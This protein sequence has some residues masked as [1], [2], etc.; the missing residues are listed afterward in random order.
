LAAAALRQSRDEPI[1]TS[2]LERWEKLRTIRLPWVSNATPEQVVHIRDAAADALPAFRARLQRD[3]ASQD[4]DVKTLVADLKV[5]ATELDA[6]LRAL[7]VKKTRRAS[8]LMTGLAC[9]VGLYGFASGMPGVAMA[10]LGIA[11]AIL[12]DAEKRRSDAEACHAEL[13]SKP[14]YV[15]LAAQRLHP[16]H[17]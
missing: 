9:S 17:K 14:A 8:S 2:D 3:L 4:A 12:K 10:G 5:E 13:T 6:K 11:S 7:N 15:L 1:A 16:P